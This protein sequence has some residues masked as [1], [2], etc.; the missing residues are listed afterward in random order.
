VSPNSAHALAECSIELS[1]K[2]CSS[3]GRVRG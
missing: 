2:R 3:D 1:L